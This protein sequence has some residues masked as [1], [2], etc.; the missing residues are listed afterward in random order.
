[1]AFY[2]NIH[3]R[4][5]RERRER[6]R[7]Q[8]AKKRGRRGKTGGEAALTAKLCNDGRIASEEMNTVAVLCD[9][10]DLCGEILML[11]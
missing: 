3:R 2:N 11:G 10:C 8:T 7:I 6:I 4:E 5:R 9:L 1:V